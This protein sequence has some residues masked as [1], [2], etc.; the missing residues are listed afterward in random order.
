MVTCLSTMRS[1]MLSRWSVT[2]SP[3]EWY[4]KSLSFAQAAINCI[5]NLSCTFPLKTPQPQSEKSKKFS[6][7]YVGNI[8]DCKEGYFRQRRQLEVVAHLHRCRSR[9][10][11]YS[12]LSI[13][14]RADIDDLECENV[15]HPW[16]PRWLISRHSDWESSVKIL[17][18]FMERYA[19]WSIIAEV[20]GVFEWETIALEIAI[21]L[22]ALK[23]N[24]LYNFDSFLKQKYRLQKI[25]IWQFVK[26]FS[27]NTHKSWFVKSLKRVFEWKLP[28]YHAGTKEHSYHHLWTHHKPDL[29]LYASDT[30]YSQKSPVKFPD[31]KIEPR[32]R[33][34]STTHP[35]QKAST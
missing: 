21:S 4:C 8:N 5:K 34:I 26:I 3:K 6:K 15:S 20:S 16:Q 13:F 17:G 33:H 31:L 7:N 28:H 24:D 9:N 35:C 27:N 14:F 11:P 30:V 23:Y 32:W 25:E 2:A 19:H 10:K 18:K 22:C 29:F 1:L 12:I